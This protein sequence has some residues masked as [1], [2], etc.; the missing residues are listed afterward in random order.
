MMIPSWRVAL[1]GTERI[2]RNAGALSEPLHNLQEL[3]SAA[4]TTYGETALFH[5]VRCQSELLTPLSSVIQATSNG[6]GTPKSA[7]F[8]L[9]LSVRNI[10]PGY[11][12]FR[13]RPYRS[14][15]ENT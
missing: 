13:D 15:I 8:P 4:V 9:Y 7:G 1:P 12:S 11:D 6:A 10:F 3:T 5:I 2:A 14:I